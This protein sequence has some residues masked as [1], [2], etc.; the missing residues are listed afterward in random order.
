MTTTHYKSTRTLL[1]LSACLLAGGAGARGRAQAPAPKAVVLTPDS[2]ARVTEGDDL[3]FQWN[4]AFDP[5]GTAVGLSE[6]ELVF[7]PHAEATPGQ[8][9]RGFNLIFTARA[10]DRDPDSPTMVIQG[11]NGSFQMRFHFSQ[12]GVPP[13]TYDLVE[14]VATPMVDPTYQGSSPQMTN[15]PLRSPYCLEVVS[16]TR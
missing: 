15:S 11:L 8:R 10:A 14:A 6:F 1:L 2:C 4:P 7:A 12:K 3:S 5:G 16:A 13:G 9:S